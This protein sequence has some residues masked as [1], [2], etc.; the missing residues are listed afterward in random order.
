MFSYPYL[1]IISK[2]VDCSTAEVSESVKIFYMHC[3][4]MSPNLS[5]WVVLNT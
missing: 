2:Q 4:P 3:C 1:F 5:F